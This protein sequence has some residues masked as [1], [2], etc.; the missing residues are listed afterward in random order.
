MAPH[1]ACQGASRRLDGAGSRTIGGRLAG[2]WNNG[3]ADAN[4]YE[5]DMKT[6]YIENLSAQ[7]SRRL[8]EIIGLTADE[9]GSRP[10]STGGQP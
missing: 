9:A 6:D 4:R 3:D 2:T 10:D 7:I 1:V 8:D 5:P